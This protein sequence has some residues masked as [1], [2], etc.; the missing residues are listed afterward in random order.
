MLGLLSELI[1]L[2]CHRYIR[3]GEELLQYGPESPYPSRCLVT[4]EGFGA[5]AAVRLGY[6]HPGPGAIRRDCIQRDAT[7]QWFYRWDE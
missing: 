2:M 7:G 3:S 1:D 6:P 5:Y 4:V